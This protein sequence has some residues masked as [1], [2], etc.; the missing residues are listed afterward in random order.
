MSNETVL[1]RI[2]Y[3]GA[4]L[5]IIVILILSFLVI[6]SVIKDTSPQASPGVAV[7][8][9]LFVI[10]IHL[11]IVAGLVRTILVIKRAGR[12]GKGPLIGIGV[13]LILFGFFILDGATAYL[14]HPDPIMHRVSVSMFVCTGFNFI[15]SILAILTALFSR[16]LQE[17]SK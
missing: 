11:L 6:P 10:F 8:G 13:V 9:I 1:R 3:V 16:R 7:P 4:G 5:V 2:L 15:A 17:T 12:T 14:D